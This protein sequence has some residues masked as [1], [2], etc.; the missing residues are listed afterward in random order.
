[1][2]SSRMHTTRFSARLGVVCV[3]GEGVCLGV[4]VCPGVACLGG[5]C[6]EGCVLRPSKIVDLGAPNLGDQGFSRRI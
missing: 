3:S 2:N 4:C 1:M 6:L 5:V